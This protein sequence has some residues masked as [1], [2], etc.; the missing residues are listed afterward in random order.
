MANF[1]T[2]GAQEVAL[3]FEKLERNA[4]AACRKAV[5]AGA[6]VLRDRLSEAAPVRTG[7]L[8]KSIKAG[9]VKYTEGDGF[10]SEVRPVG[11]NH[12]EPLAKIGNILEYGR[13]NMPPR[14]WFLPTVD[15]ARDE[16]EDA[17]RAEFKKVQ[18]S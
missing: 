12:G 6:K 4:D 15:K 16:V 14:P 3:R 7:A 1:K 17:M 18:G 13:S 10:V 2:T 8:A 5:A 11:D 9:T